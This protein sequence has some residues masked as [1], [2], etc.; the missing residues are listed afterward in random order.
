MNMLLRRLLGR[1]PQPRQARKDSAPDTD[2]P[3]TTQDG[4][5]NA[6]RRQLVLVLLRD[7]LRRHGIAPH[8]IE[9]QMLVVNRASHGSDVHVRLVLKHW[10]AR[11]LNY[12][13]AFQNEL[14]TDIRRFEPKASEWLQGISWQLEMSESC[15]YPTLP[16]RAFWQAPQ[17]VETTSSAALPAASVNQ[18]SSAVKPS[19]PGA[20]GN[21]MED[22]A[23]LFSI[24]D[25]EISRAAAAAG[26]RE[27][28]K[29]QPLPL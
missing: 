3:V 6:M 7:V 18:V 8:W 22:L 23:Q 26:P 4:S 5:D 17:A 9:L 14:L 25:H 10:D 20:Q 19:A 28:E 29:T 21:A 15:P 16:D 13:Q 11:L 1:A 12:A 2:S 27:Y 24:R